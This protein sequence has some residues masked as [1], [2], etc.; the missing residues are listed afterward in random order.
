MKRLFLC[1]LC[2]AALATASGAIPPEGVEDGVLFTVDASAKIEEMKP[3]WAWFGYDE[4]NYTHMKDGV[5]LISEISEL[6]PVPAYAR[7]HNLLTSGDG[8]ASLKWGSTNAYTE[9]REGRP[10]YDWTILD[11]IFDTYVQRGVKPFVE[12]GFMP[13]ALSTNPDPYRHS[14]AAVNSGPLWTGWTSMEISPPP[15]RAIPLRKT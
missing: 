3:L 11:R 12:I 6:S 15:R 8:S 7:A 14:W 1:A 5:K 13:E 4:P 9:D 2:L 10:I